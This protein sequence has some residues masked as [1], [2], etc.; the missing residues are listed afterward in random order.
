MPNTFVHLG[1]QTLGSKALLK[2]SDF[3]WIAVGCIIPD[4]PWILHVKKSLKP[5]AVPE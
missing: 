3:K 5:S 2:G 1:I 4:L